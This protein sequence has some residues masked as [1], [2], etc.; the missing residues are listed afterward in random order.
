M[1]CSCCLSALAASF[2][3]SLTL[4]ERLKDFL[5]ISVY[6]IDLPLLTIPGCLL[7]PDGLLGALYLCIQTIDGLNT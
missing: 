5:S 1:R 2:K 6:F 3:Y 4:S 7:L